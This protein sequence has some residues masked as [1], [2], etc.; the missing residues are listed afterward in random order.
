[1]G[2]SKKMQEIME[3]IK[4]RRKELNLSYQELADKSGFGKSTLHRYETGSINTMPV[5]RFEFLASAL[6]IEPYK[7]MG[8]NIDDILKS[9][10]DQCDTNLADLF[11]IYERLNK[12]GKRK[13]IE[14]S[15][16]L[17]L[18]DKYLSSNKD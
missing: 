1:M 14:Y 4:K 11:K 13:L 16:D 7:L 9:S 3:R 2:S 18:I 12:D 17:I 10:I 8:W 15:L 5:D 6:E